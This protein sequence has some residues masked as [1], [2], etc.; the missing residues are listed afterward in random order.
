MYMPDT[1]NETPDLSRLP[2]TIE[3]P[4]NIPAPT[5]VTRATSLEAVIDADV[6]VANNCL[7]LLHATLPS[8]RTV[9]TLIQVVNATM[10]TV[11]QRR[12]MLN[13]QYGHSDKSAK[14]EGVITPD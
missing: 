4:S 9:A 14:D 11:A 13:L 12:K 3:V 8:V 5:E 7:R 2:H 10:S 6:E 1:E